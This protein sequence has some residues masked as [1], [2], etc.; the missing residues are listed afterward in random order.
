MRKVFVVGG[1]Q[2]LFTPAQQKTQVE[3]F[4]ETAMDAMAAANVKSKDI[5]AIFMGNVLGDF[6]EGQAMVQAF[7][8]ESIG[9]AGVPANRYEGACASASVAVRDAF[10]WV[11]SG[12]YDIV[13]VGGVERAASLGTPLATRTFAMASDRSYEFPSGLTFPAVFAMLAHLYA[14]T[15]D[16]PLE[17]VKEEM[18]TV[19][20]QSYKRGI[21]NEK[22]QMRKEVTIE[23]V[24]SSFMVSTPLQLHDCCPFSDGAAAVILASEDA[25]KKLSAKPVQ[26][27]GVGQASAGPLHSQKK[28]L[29][30]IYSREL[31]VKQAYGMAGV[32]PKDIDVCELHDCFSIASLI[33]AES[34]GFFDYGKSGEAWMEGKADIGGVVA[35]N[36]SGGLKSRGHPIGATGAAQVYEIFR[37]LRNEVEP[38]RQVP[39]A[40]IGLTDTLGGDGGTLVNIIMKRGW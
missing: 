13:L 33:A 17:Q 28:T 16:K 21:H 36:P 27:I 5:Q 25:V 9:C 15:Y 1:A 31:S 32:G 29:P 22:A 8:A 4:S 6:S 24:L 3:L 40:K 7:A 26:I 37:Q 23:Q 35:I 30:R 10:M 39:D 20:V 12:F 14:K 34:L 19:S 2:S 38:Q 18:A 11:A